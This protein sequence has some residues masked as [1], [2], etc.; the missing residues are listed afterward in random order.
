MPIRTQS[1]DIK[2]FSLPNVQAQRNRNRL[3]DQRVTEMQNF[4]DRAPQRHEL[5]DLLR[6]QKGIE[7]GAMKTAASDQQMYREGTQIKNA[8]NLAMKNPS[9][10]GE[11]LGRLS[12][13]GHDV[14]KL[15]QQFDPQAIGRILQV[16]EMELPKFAAKAFT[17]KPGEIRYEGGQEVARGAEKPGAAPKTV[18]TKE[19]VFVLNHDGTLGNRLGNNY[20]GAGATKDTAKITNYRFYQGL[21]E[22]DKRVFDHLQ[23][24]GLVKDTGNQL[25]LIDPVKGTSTVLADKELTPAQEP[26]HLAE[27]E[28][29]KGEAKAK[30]D[31]TTAADEKGVKSEQALS[32]LEG[33]EKLIEQSTG[34]WGGHALDTL[35]AAFG[36]ARPGAIAVGKL[37]VLQANLMLS[38]PRMEGPQSD[39]DVNLYREAA[40]Q[41]G[42]PTVPNAVKQAAV[43]TIR[44]LHNKYVRAS[45]RSDAELNKKYNLD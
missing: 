45:G 36:E 37:K 28:T 8:L 26:A 22:K 33:V 30:V 14:S 31:A 17:L 34:S 35:Y 1:L 2:P 44:E 10:Y 29:V 5:A 32:A 7:V 4:N 27:V 16:T 23:R 12:K 3:A 9:L 42:D 15:P 25:I 24:Q 43:E 11:I 21:N 6:E 13:R 40:G 18:R 39:K 19:G 20:G 38:Q 41:I